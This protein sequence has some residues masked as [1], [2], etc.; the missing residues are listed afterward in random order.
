MHAAYLNYEY[1]LIN[2]QHRV[3]SRYVTSVEE[4]WHDIRKLDDGRVRPKTCSDRQGNNFR[5]TGFTG[6]V[7]HPEF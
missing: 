2:N 1:I 7:H 4:V 3:H 5:I 6:F